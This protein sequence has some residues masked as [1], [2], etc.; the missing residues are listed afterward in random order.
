MIHDENLPFLMQVVRS[1]MYLLTFMT[2]VEDVWVV[3]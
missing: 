2:F 1:K 3:Q